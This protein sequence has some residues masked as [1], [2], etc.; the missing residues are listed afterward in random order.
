MSETTI[1]GFVYAGTCV[2][3]T[4][5]TWSLESNYYT[6]VV[7]GFDS[8]V[9]Y[10]RED[11]GRWIAIFPPLPGV[12]RYGQSKREA[13]EAVRRLAKEVVRDRIKHNESVPRDA[14]TAL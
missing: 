9:E 6:P 4:Q 2:T 3:S 1:D 7:R 11:D 14:L 13:L 12:M 5:S 10:D 8:L